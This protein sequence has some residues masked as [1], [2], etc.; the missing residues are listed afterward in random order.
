M[1]RWKMSLLKKYNRRKLKSILLLV[2]FFLFSLGASGQFK[3]KKSTVSAG[4]GAYSGGA[5]KTTISIGDPGT[6][7]LSGGG[8]KIITGFY[9]LSEKNVTPTDIS[10]SNNTIDENEASATVG[11]LTTTDGNL[12]DIHT[13]SLVAG[14]GD[15]DNASFQINGD[16]LEAA[17]SLNFEPPGKETYSVR[18]KTL[19]YRGLSFEES[20]TITV[21]NVNDPPEN[22]LLDGGT[23]AAVNENLT[24]GQT[25]GTLASTDQDIDDTFTYSLPAGTPDNSSF[26]IVGALLKTGIIF[27]FEIRNTYNIKVRTTDGGGAFFEKDMVININDVNDSPTLITRATTADIPENQPNGTAVTALTTSD[28]D[29]GDTFTYTLVAGTGDVDNDLFQIPGSVLQIKDTL[30]FERAGGPTFAYRLQ[31]RDASNATYEE[32]FTVTVTDVDDPPRDVFLGSNEI[33]EGKD[34]GTSI[35]FMVVV[36]DD[37]FA[38]DHTFNLVPG[39]GSD[40]NALFQL[41]ET[42]G[43]LKSGA[44]FNFASK[45]TYTI[46]VRATDVD[47][48]TLFIEKVQS[49]QILPEGSNAK[50]IDIIL[51][52]VEIREITV[53]GSLVGTFT[54]QDPDL[55]DTHTY[56][57]I[58]GTG[59]D[60]N[61]SFTITGDQLFLNTTLD[62]DIQSLYS[63]L[64]ETDD[65]NSGR[66]SKVYIITI[67]EFINTTPTDVILSS[68]SVDETAPTSTTVGTFSSTDPDPDETFTYTLVAGEGDTD[69]GSFTISGIDLKTNTDFDYLV[70]NSYSIRVQVEDSNG[71]IFE[72]ILT[73]FISDTRPPVV[74]TL[75]PADEST[76]AT[77]SVELVITFNE[78]VNVGTGNISIIVFAT[79]ILIEAVPVAGNLVSGDGTM[80]ITINPI[81]DLEGTV[82]YYV[83]VES[84][85]FIDLAGNV[86]AGWTNNATWNFTT[87]NTAPTDLLLTSATIDETSSLETVVGNLGASDIDPGESF[88]FTLVAGEGDTD[89]G[90][91]TIVGTQ[92]KTN[93]TFDFLAQ[94]TYSIRVQVEDSHG[95]TY[96]EILVITILDTRPP[97]ILTMSP[98]NNSVDVDKTTNLTL[99][100]NEPVIAGTGNI[101][102]VDSS[103]ETAVETIDVT[104]SSLT[105]LG[106]ELIAIDLKN[107]LSGGLTYYLT[108]DEGALTDLAGNAFPGISVATDWRFTTYDDVA[109]VIT[110]Q[111]VQKTHLAQGSSETIS[112]NVN[113]VSSV[114]VTFNYG[115]ILKPLDQLTTLAASQDNN[116]YSAT[117]DDSF[118]DN[119]GLKYFFYAED[120][121]GNSS[122]SEIRYMFLTLTTAENL[123]GLKFGGTIDDY[124][125]IAVP[126][127]LEDKRIRE[128][129]SAY[130]DYDDTKWR[131]VRYNT[132]KD[133]YEDF[134]DFTT[135]DIGK[136][137]WFNAKEQHEIKLANRNMPQVTPTQ[138]FQMQLKLGWNQIGNPFTIPLNWDQVLDDNNITDQVQSLWIY[139]S[140]PNLTTG[141]TL[142]PFEGGF[143]K[144]N[145]LITL[146]LFPADGSSLRTFNKKLLEN[147]TDHEAWMIPLSLENDKFIYESGYFGMHPEALETYD[148]FD[149]SRPPHFIRHMDYY[150]E[151]ENDLY[152]GNMV[153][154]S[155]EFIWTI[156]VDANIKPGLMA[157]NW[158]AEKIGANSEMILFDIDKQKIVDMKLFNRYRFYQD[159]NKKF[160]IYYNVEPEEITPD[161]TLLGTPYPN[162]FDKTT[163]IPFTLP[164]NKEYQISLK[165]SDVLGNEVRTL[166]EGTFQIGFHEI[167]WNGDNASGKK[168]DTGIY[169]VQLMV[170]DG[171]NTETFTSRVILQ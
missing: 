97:N 8:F 100:F 118:F 103:S 17:V 107:V 165:I 168:V 63:I 139:K 127:V 64:V 10:L 30:N 39:T 136:G 90:S 108:I 50:P 4:G 104:S 11:V 67:L 56:A 171:N 20:F 59:D 14:A 15:T 87:I 95:G 145:N 159:G 164:E 157:L 128:V 33:V 130:G 106:T 147:D 120:A 114:N 27:N 142:N 44:V 116:T 24:T 3:I 109:P 53:T 113:D 12:V 51:D 82:E 80:V 152:A 48:P 21:I 71:G 58:T 28:E 38:D 77:K 146:N 170:D 133:K 148:Q 144:A 2:S 156:T 69:N 98:D 45:S 81:A 162:P 111:G 25:L 32:A 102:I 99:S 9:P 79:E 122:T 126:Y 86:F 121:N 89:N 75:S 101:K 129:F 131:L 43:E 23:T 5:F 124:Q 76:D 167:H 117:V 135:I 62:F 36:D 16:I 72:I 7:L 94:D 153:G 123:A 134:P 46:R 119:I 141:S 35:G 110:Y 163:V 52:N 61:G 83:T 132:E 54:T 140:G 149:L 150:F 85:A 74:S 161:K 42:S 22:V 169:I 6:A 92:L 65:G 125:I 47:D 88:T 70:K 78:A 73:I 57:L 26:T 1:I 49:I 13:Y 160:R 137:Y 115:G 166:I 40:D 154:T 60:D 155:G 18:I 29:A 19:D 93:D 151:M 96:E 143:V 91:F 112:V 84:G 34:V 158:P 105:G 41:N 138:G 55:G 37:G 68:S 66:Y 31:T